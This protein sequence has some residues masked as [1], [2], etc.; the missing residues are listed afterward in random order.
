MQTSPAQPVA[1]AAYLLFRVATEHYALAGTWVR[2]VMRWRVPTPVP[3]AP[4]LLPGVINRR[5]QIL[6]VIDLRLLLGFTAATPDRATR[7]I[8]VHHEAVDAAL[9]V[10]AVDD[11]ITIDPAQL[12]P[13]PVTLTGTAQRV[14]QAIYRWH[15]QPVAILD[16]AATLVLVQEAV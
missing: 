5:G 12:E 15:D 9:L 13:P 14:I 3:G 2:E 6:A 1:S 7:L 10:D 16:L 4:A 11:L 8:W